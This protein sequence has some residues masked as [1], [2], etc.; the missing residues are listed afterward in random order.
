MA[1]IHANMNIDIDTPMGGRSN[2][3]NTYSSRKLL[4]NLSQTLFSLY[5]H[6]Q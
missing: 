2:I 3:S 4:A 5:L 1:K 6:N